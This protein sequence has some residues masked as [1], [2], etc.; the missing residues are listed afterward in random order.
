MPPIAVDDLKEQV[1]A[2]ITDAD[3]DQARGRAAGITFSEVSTHTEPLVD[4]L[5][6]P[7]YILWVYIGIHRGFHSSVHRRVAVYAPTL[8]WA[9]PL[10]AYRPTLRHATF[11][12]PFSPL[13]LPLFQDGKRATFPFG[14]K[15]LVSTMDTS[16]GNLRWIFKSSGNSSWAVGAIPRS[17]ID[18][19]DVM[20]AEQSIAV[21]T[22]SL[23]GGRYVSPSSCVRLLLDNL[24]WS[25]DSLM[26][27]PYACPHHLMPLSPSLQGVDAQADPEPRAGGGAQRRPWALD[28]HA[29]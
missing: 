25:L 23:T 4:L 3:F 8:R 11:H 16:T 20:M 26:H 22:T 29:E 18:R 5:Y 27:P 10:M 21:A 12:L 1:G 28:R 13:P 7:I 17:K 19:H 2:V 24:M 15:L 6:I 14:P 9:G